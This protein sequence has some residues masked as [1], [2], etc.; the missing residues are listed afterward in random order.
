M[1]FAALGRRFQRTVRTRDPFG[2]ALT[3]LRRAVRV[4]LAPGQHLPISDI[5]AGLRLSTSP[6]REAL[7]RLC[8]EGLVE[9]RRGLGYFTRGASTED[10]VGL[11]QLEE[12]HVRLA[13]E[14]SSAQAPPAGTDVDL[15]SWIVA[16]ILECESDPLKESFER[17]ADRLKPIRALAQAEDIGAA[18]RHDTIQ[19]YYVRWIGAAPGLARRMRRLQ[20]ADVEYTDNAV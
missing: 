19:A 15:E 13:M 8:G 10:I 18:V 11:F 16:L 2:R 7:S 4:G 1:L 6:V 20:P 14:L 9:D 12:A 3:A 5:A 17:V